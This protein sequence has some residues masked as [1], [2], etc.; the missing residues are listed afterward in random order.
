MSVDVITPLELNAIDRILKK[1]SR[2]MD[3]IKHIKHDFFL[4]KLSSSV[5][6]VILRQGDGSCVPG[7]L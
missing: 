4:F 3:I 6:R 2:Q 7:Y 1:I 5:P